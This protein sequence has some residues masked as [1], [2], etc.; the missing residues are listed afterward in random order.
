MNRFEDIWKRGFAIFVV[1]SLVLSSV[2]VKAVE[3]GEEGFDWEKA[4]YEKIDYTKITDINSIPQQYYSKIPWSKFPKEVIVK[5]SG[6]ARIRELVKVLEVQSKESLKLLTSAQVKNIL[7]EFKDLSILNHAEVAKALVAKGEFPGGAVLNLVPGVVYK[8]GKL[9][10]PKFPN[11]LG[12]KSLGSDV[13]SVSA[14]VTEIGT[15]GF[16]ICKG[17]KCNEVTSAIAGE[18]TGVSRDKDGNLV[19]DTTNGPVKLDGNIRAVVDVSGDV[20]YLTDDGTFIQH[21]GFSFTARG[22][23]QKTNFKF[24]GNKLT[25]EGPGEVSSDGNRVSGK[26][27]GSFTVEIGLTADE[28]KVTGNKADITVYGKDRYTGDFSN[29]Y[30]EGK[31]MMFSL[32][33]YMS[34][35]KIRGHLAITNDDNIK[36][37]YITQNNPN[38]KTL[39]QVWH[40]AAV[41]TTFNEEKL[42][43]DKLKDADVKKYVSDSIEKNKAKIEALKAAKEKAKTDYEKSQIQ[44]KIDYLEVY[45]KDLEGITTKAALMGVVDNTISRLEADNARIWK[46]HP[47]T[48]Y[49]E[50]VNSD[51]NLYGDKKS[52]DSIPGRLVILPGKSSYGVSELDSR[53]MSGE[54]ANV[55]SIYSPPEYS[56]ASGKDLKKRGIMYCASGSTGITGDMCSARAKTSVGLVEIMSG[57]DSSGN[58]YSRVSRNSAVK[59]NVDDAGLIVVGPTSKDARTSMI[60]LDADGIHAID[61]LVGEGKSRVYT[62]PTIIDKIAEN[63]KKVRDIALG[64]L[65][66]AGLLREDEKVS[67][68]ARKKAQELKQRLAATFVE[69]FKDIREF[70]AGE[71]SELEKRMPGVTQKLIDLNT[72]KVEQNEQGL[73]SMLAAEKDEQMKDRIRASILD[74]YKAQGETGKEEAWLKTWEQQAPNSK[75]L[76]TIKSQRAQQ[77]TL[78]VDY[79]KMTNAELEALAETKPTVAL[80]QELTNRY[81]KDKDYAN[82][83]KYADLARTEVTLGLERAE[84]NLEKAGYS[85]LFDMTDRMTTVYQTLADVSLANKDNLLAE[86]A[87]RFNLAINKRNYRAA[88]TLSAALIAQDKLKDNVAAWESY[89]NENKD[90]SRLYDRAGVNLIDAYTRIKAYD[91]VEEKY[92]DIEVT[93]NTDIKKEADVAYVR[94][95]NV[96]SSELLKDKKYDDALAKAKRALQVDKNDKFSLSVMSSVASSYYSSKRYDDSIALLEDLKNRK[97]S[98]TESEKVTLAGAYHGKGNIAKAKGLY[99]EVKDAFE[100]KGVAK[101]SNTD[102]FSYAQALD[103]LGESDKS[104][105]VWKQL[106]QITPANDNEKNLKSIA[107]NVVSQI[108]T[109]RGFQA[110]LK[111]ITE[112]QE[113]VQAYDKVVDGL[114]SK[115]ALRLANSIAGKADKFT[116]EADAKAFLKKVGQSNFQVAEARAISREGLD[117][118]KQGLQQVKEGKDVS[119]AL[120]TYNGGLDTLLKATISPDKRKESGGK[121]DNLREKIQILK[122]QIADAKESRDKAPSGWFGTKTK[123]YETYNSLYEARLKDLDAAQ[124]EYLKLRQQI[125]SGANLADKRELIKLQEDLLSELRGQKAQGYLGSAETVRQLEETT[126]Q[127]IAEVAGQ[128]G[129]LLERYD[130]QSSGLWTLIVSEKEKLRDRSYNTY[131]KQGYT[132]EQA[133]DMA[134]K[135][136]QDYVNVRMKNI[137]LENADLFQKDLL[138]AKTK[139]QQ[140]SLETDN[141]RREAAAAHA[142]GGWKIGQYVIVSNRNIDIVKNWW[143]SDG[144][145]TDYTKKAEVGFLGNF[146]YKVANG[147]SK[148]VGLFLEVGLPVAIGSL[149]ANVKDGVLLASGSATTNEQTIQEKNKAVA[150]NQQIIQGLQYLSKITQET[151]SADMEAL[152]RAVKSKSTTGLTDSQKKLYEKYF[153]GTEGTKAK[154]SVLLAVTDNRLNNQDFGP[155]GVLEYASG[156]NDLTPEEIAK[157]QALLANA[158]KTEY[159]KDAR[160]KL[161]AGWGLDEKGDYFADSKGNYLSL[162]AGGRLLGRLIN[163]KE[164]LTQVTHL[165]WANENLAGVLNF[166]GTSSNEYEKLKYLNRKGSELAKTTQMVK[167]LEE[168]KFKDLSAIYNNEGDV[169]SPEQH[170]EYRQLIDLDVNLRTARLVEKYGSYDKIPQS[171]IQAINRLK[172]ADEVGRYNWEAAKGYAQLTQDPNLVSQVQ[173]TQT[174]QQTLNRMGETAGFFANMAIFGAATRGLSSLGGKILSSE[175][176]KTLG[177]IVS[178][179]QTGKK[180]IDFATKYAD[181]VRLG[182]MAEQI[183]DVTNNLVKESWMLKLKNKVVKTIWKNADDA[184]VQTADDALAQITS[185]KN[186]FVNARA[187]GDV[188]KANQIT[189]QIAR[190]QAD[191]LAKINGQ[192]LGLAKQ[193]AQMLVKSAS[194]EEIKEEAQE[195]LA[196]DIG[197]NLKDKLGGSAGVLAEA[198]V[199]FYNMRKGIVSGTISSAD[200]NLYNNQLKTASNA[201]LKPFVDTNFQNKVIVFDGNNYDFKTNP[202]GSITLINSDGVTV[203]KIDGLLDL[204]ALVR[205]GRVQVPGVVDLNVLVDKAALDIPLNVENARTD[206]EIDTLRTELLDPGITAERKAEVQARIESLESHKNEIGKSIDAQKSNV[207]IKQKKQELAD[208]EQQGDLNKIQETT[209]ALREAETARANSLSELHTAQIEGIEARKRAYESK[210]AETKKTLAGETDAKVQAEIEAKLNSLQALLLDADV[211]ILAAES[212]KLEAEIDSLRKQSKIASDT[213]KARLEQEIEQKR[214][215][216]LDKSIQQKEAEIEREQAVQQTVA[217][218]LKKVEGDTT[219]LFVGSDISG[220]RALQDATDRLIEQKQEQKETL[221]R[222]KEFNEKEGNDDVKR[223]QNELEERKSDFFRDVEDYHALKESEKESEAGKALRAKLENEQKAITVNQLQIDAA[224][225]K[226][227]GTTEPVS[228]E[229]RLQ[230]KALEKVESSIKEDQQLDTDEKE[231]VSELTKLQNEKQKKERQVEYVEGEMAKPDVGDEYELDGKKYKVTNILTIGGKTYYEVQTESGEIRG[232][233]AEKIQAATKISSSLTAKRG[234]LNTIRIQLENDINNI[235]TQEKTVE[236]NS[237]TK[238]AQKEAEKEPE[239]VTKEKRITDLTAQINELDGKIAEAE[240]NGDFVSLEDQQRLNR[241]KLERGTLELDLLLGKKLEPTEVEVAKEQQVKALTAQINELGAKIAEAERRGDFVSAEDQQTLERLKTQRAGLEL[242][243]LLGADFE[244]AEAVQPELKIGEPAKVTEDAGTLKQQLQQQGVRQDLI[245]QAGD[246]IGQLETLLRRAGTPE[247]RAEARQFARRVTPS[248]ME[249]SRLAELTSEA[250]RDVGSVLDAISGVS[251]QRGAVNL[252]SITLGDI[253]IKIGYGRSPWLGPIYSE[254]VDGQWQIQIDTGRLA[255]LFASLDTQQE[256][257]LAFKALIAHELGEIAGV[258]N[259][260]LVADD[261]HVIGAKIAKNVLGE[262]TTDSKQYIKVKQALNNFAWAQS[263]PINIEG[264]MTEGIRQRVLSDYHF[265]NSKLAYDNHLVRIAGGEKATR[266]IATVYHKVGKTFKVIFEH[267]NGEV[268]IATIDVMDFKNQINTRYG[269]IVGD[270]FITQI[271]GALADAM[272]NWDGSDVTTYLNNLL[273]DNDFKQNIIN[274][275]P[276][277]KVE[278]PLET[279]TESKG[280]DRKLKLGEFNFYA[281]VSERSTVDSI[282]GAQRLNDQSTVAGKTAELNIGGVDIDLLAEVQNRQPEDVLSADTV[283]RLTGGSIQGSMTLDALLAQLKTKQGTK[284][285]EFADTNDCC[286]TKA[287]PQIFANEYEFFGE[288]ITTADMTELFRQ[289]RRAITEANLEQARQL[290]EAIWESASLNQEFGGYLDGNDLFKLATNKLLDDRGDRDFAQVFIIGGDEVGIV[291]SGNGRVTFGRIDINNFGKTNQRYG[292]EYADALKV[293]ILKIIQRNIEGEINADTAKKINTEILTYVQSTGREF[294][295]ELMPSVSIGIINVDSRFNEIDATKLNELADAASE[296]IKA[297]SKARITDTRTTADVVNEGGFFTEAEPDYEV[298]DKPRPT[299]I[300]DSLADWMFNFDQQQRLKTPEQKKAD[301]LNDLFSDDVWQQS[302]L[303]GFLHQTDN[304]GRTVQQRLESKLQSGETAEDVVADIKAGIFHRFPNDYIPGN[305]EVLLQ[306]FINDVNDIDV[307]TT[308]DDL[309]DKGFTD[310]TEVGKGAVGNVFKAERAGETVAVKT[311]QREKAT[312]EAVALFEKE[313]QVLAQLDHP[314]VVKAKESGVKDARPYFTQEYVEGEGLDQKVAEAKYQQ[315]PLSV[316]EVS[317]VAVQLFDALQYLHD[318]GIIHRDIKPGNIIVEPDGTIKLIDFGFAGFDQELRERF[319]LEGI[320]QVGSAPYDAPEIFNEKRMAD[321]FGITKFDETK[322]DIYAAAWMVYE[323]LTLNSPISSGLKADVDYKIDTDLL[324]ANGVPENLIQVLE[325]ALAQNPNERPDAASLKAAFE[326]TTTPTGLEA[327]VEKSGEPVSIGKVI[328]GRYDVQTSIGVGG[329]GQTFTAVDQE[330]GRT[331]VIK[332]FEPKTMEP[333]AVEQMKELF[334]EEA[335]VLQRLSHDGIVKVFDA[336]LEG[337]NPYIVEEHVNGKTLESMIG[338]STDPMSLETVNDIAVKVLGIVEYMHQQGVIHRDLNPNNI[339]ITPDGDVKIIDFGLAGFDKEFRT[340]HGSTGFTGDFKYGS[341]EQLDL[342]GFM[343]TAESDPEYDEKAMDAYTIGTVLYNMMTKNNPLG[344][345]STATSIGFLGKKGVGYDAVNPTE[346][347]KDIPNVIAD[348][349]QR[350]VTKDYKQRPTVAEIKKAFDNVDEDINVFGTEVGGTPSIA[351]INIMEE[352]RAASSCG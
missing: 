62:N 25:M 39:E 79:S 133:K 183:D 208:A 247:S 58:G 49:L 71:L 59:N 214:K 289:R 188:T 194:F 274:K 291:K 303:Q 129:F 318:R 177:R 338:E 137:G 268:Q 200:V 138:D 348:V 329:F 191:A 130:Q 253:E 91:K 335:K 178:K 182:Q 206:A 259:G 301:A 67:E 293:Q 346:F 70:V 150:K 113:T 294:S 260:F 327:I 310:V 81:L 17:T 121:L 134:E 270:N 168:G 26:V 105:E 324:R 246:D 190:I 306:G 76:A 124:K 149:V 241:L 13:T 211:E 97:G 197:K 302:P 106:S 110:A 32:D 82:A 104:Y 119:Q 282:P 9:I 52:T 284:V 305:I 116:K 72:Y 203:K 165:A 296:R 275:V 337:D 131:L 174:Y 212:A 118:V 55:Y 159:F 224:V 147:V 167:L 126:D 122:R 125:L 111:G 242:E 258:E 232:F 226:S 99:G 23:T 261:S 109:T 279:D 162:E 145:L 42:N 292:V 93:K 317:D 135:Q 68:E 51:V 88:Q 64:V 207:D 321:R 12:I 265:R 41:I 285:L 351:T 83:Q 89:S 280:D 245:D 192:Y 320:P 333:A 117:L 184:A 171:E 157:R 44:S 198:L 114:S 146:G 175:P 233:T 316:Q 344:L 187:A 73:L 43:I 341:P 350:A 205:E 266:P 45:V 179:S 330:T 251:Y 235:E 140:L 283:S 27:E 61:S 21:K 10:N 87:S 77:Q 163:P 238:D 312:P 262:L 102:K 69:E 210:I 153:T 331:V 215:Q 94:S 336:A 176:A 151:S 20:V 257:D 304:Q 38:A 254:Q 48:G 96:Q 181:D 152:A 50:V 154:E 16:I 65:R 2:S 22:T 255:S 112:K 30:K 345:P 63:Y 14:V 86:D 143:A 272:A 90:A 185:L 273:N 229:G 249:R 239:Q 297:E 78:R 8:D 227:L 75:W 120:A 216:L 56:D 84:F 31:L 339:I 28:F 170:K 213:E 264:E 115:D 24:K 277:Q 311:L 100:K 186:Q 107:Q 228:E 252:D 221:E 352:A 309:V 35:A 11:G 19:I 234:V 195:E 160:N 223:Q 219:G 4:D 237:D 295:Q 201:M 299:P 269:H 7:G 231:A 40:N 166:F 326:T 46:T 169:L 108:D 325:R 132:A 85:D 60:K 315:R 164:T 127:F 263:D 314:N 47:N 209:T 80:Y 308:I 230:K 36:K 256:R 240:R 225:Q 139:R 286:K 343:K 161:L 307:E 136:A 243:I 66:A 290:T 193:G 156:V 148:T 271:G 1:L 217:D 128:Y 95:L 298:I 244:A 202:D 248:Q 313:P 5:F 220:L 276:N 323:M 158:Q 3:P 29:E 300:T 173:D 222:Q 204:Q 54:Q 236:E 180:I 98:L 218:E 328:G 340:R 37:V 250:Q 33:S 172:V 101:L 103:G 349:L 322:V 319:G 6:D 53:S 34:S 189:Q 334:R 287:V 196:G 155:G 342:D 142:A 57:R 278:A 144:V 141:Q 123:E 92:L 18:F 347:N 74:V 15:E 267:G 288:K 199:I 281:G 332:A